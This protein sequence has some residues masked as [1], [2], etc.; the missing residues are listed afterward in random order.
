VKLDRRTIAVSAALFLG[1]LLV[2]SRAIGNDFVNYDDP[3]YVTENPRVQAG[4]T[5]KGIRWA[6]TTSE[7]ANWHPLTWISHM[8]DW[9]VFEDDPRG[10]HAVSVV[11]HALNT[12]LVFFLFRRLTN[13]F[14][15]SAFSA[16]LFA[17]HP[18]RIESVAWIAERKDVL[19][20][21]F[22][23]LALWAY[24]VYAQQRG[25]KWYWLSLGTFALG[26]LAKPMLVTLPVIML[27]LDIWP[28][29]RLHSAPRLEKLPFFLLAAG[30]CAIT[31]AV[32]H[33]GGSI[34][35]VLPLRARIAN[36][37]VAIPGYLGNFFWPNDLAVLYPHPGF[38]SATTIGASVSLFV[39]VTAAAL[40]QFRDRPWLAIGWFWFLLVLLPVL[41]FVQI[42]LHYMADRYTYLPI[43]GLQ[44]ALLPAFENSR[45]PVLVLAAVAVLSAC[46]LRTWS[47]LGVWKNSFT[48]F[49]HAL[50]VTHNNYLAYNNRGLAFDRA[51]QLDEA[52]ADYRQA[53]TIR[54][55][56][57]EANNNLGQALTEHGRPRDGLAMFRAALNADPNLLAAHN[58][59]GNALADDG[60]PAEALPH[61]DFVLAREPWNVSALSNSGIALSMLGRYPEAIA[62]L[63]KAVR[64][65]P[66][67]LNAQRNLAKAR[68]MIEQA[69]P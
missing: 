67:N 32:Q 3:V 2:F 66:D 27:L 5:L 60:K 16:A 7:A 22:G 23:L 20:G 9:S 43:L 41:G 61:Y 69:G 45:R 18:L 57:P 10:H 51:G 39:L 21:F 1:T 35:T 53:L 38:W 49:D 58:N 24:V 12:V 14:W 55:D 48:L 65:A 68:A 33:A 25:A 34:S 42:G 36:G 17:W 59:L 28:L 19:S 62:R 54:P 64:L 26:L 31:L 50:S 46:V 47:Q 15:L 63:E 8:V 37:F 56:Y 29:Q 40:S 11:W 4:L 6:L 13:A 52:M 30:S 44:L